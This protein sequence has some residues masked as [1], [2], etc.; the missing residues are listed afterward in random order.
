MITFEG[1]SRYNERDMEYSRGPVESPITAIAKE[2]ALPRF[3]AN[4]LQ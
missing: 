3:A 1:I 4:L 2:R